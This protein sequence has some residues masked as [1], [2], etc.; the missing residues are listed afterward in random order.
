MKAC[1]IW[2]TCVTC[3]L[4]Q[5]YINKMCVCVW[6]HNPAPA[7]ECYCN[8]IITQ[9]HCFWHLTRNS[10]RG[11]ERGEKNL[12]E[13]ISLWFRVFTA[14]VL[15]VMAAFFIMLISKHHPVNQIALSTDSK[16]ASSRDGRFEIGAIYSC[17][18]SWFVAVRP[19]NFTVDGKSL[20][21]AYKKG[22]KGYRGEAIRL[23]LL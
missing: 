1:C 18:M 2:T 10:E 16:F 6:A 8:K 9:P 19:L 23:H 21:S 15:D 5:F 12:E 11:E 4:F 22:R 3:L 14:T 20:K 17:V 7:V 13:N